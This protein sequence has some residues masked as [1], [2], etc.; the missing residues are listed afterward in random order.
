MR[1]LLGLGV[2]VVSLC[3]TPLLAREPVLLGVFP[4]RVLVEIDGQRLVLTMGAEVTEGVRLL[5]PDTRT[6]TAWLE[7]Q[8]ERRQFSSA[9]R[10]EGPR[11]PDT[12]AQARVY[13][14]TYGSLTVAGSINGHAVRFLVD[15]EAPITTLGAGEAQRLGIA[16]ARGDLIQARTAA[17][18]SFGYRVILDQVRIGGIVLDEVEAVV[19]QSD[20]PRL[21][22]LGASFLNRVQV[23]R[24]GSALLLQQQP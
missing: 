17:G 5:S 2:L 16:Y 3:C 22:V 23:Q 1:G 18:L 19:L 11:R 8:G 6:G 24:Q 14:D 7:V 21:P 10:T 20:A 4:D 15:T 9:R 12:A 13:P